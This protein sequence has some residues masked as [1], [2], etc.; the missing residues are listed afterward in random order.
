MNQ[1]GHSRKIIENKSIKTTHRSCCNKSNLFLLIDFCVIASSVNNRFIDAGFSISSLSIKSLS[2]ENRSNKKKHTIFKNRNKS[3][4]FC[5]VGFTWL[6]KLH[7]AYIWTFLMTL[8]N[9]GCWKKGCVIESWVFKDFRK[10][11]W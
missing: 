11:F 9:T 8:S 6:S 10:H 2:K 1:R 7:T 5:V 3:K 4:H